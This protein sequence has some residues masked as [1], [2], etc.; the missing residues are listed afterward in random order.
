MNIMGLDYVEL[1][2]EVQTEF[3]VNI[4]DSDAT[5]ITTVG[6]FFDVIVELLGTEPSDE[7]YSGAIWDRYVALI[8]QRT[9]MPRE[10]I[11]PSAR[12]VEDFG[13]D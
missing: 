13:L 4:A 12:F 9:D 2:M 11:V 1:V 7:R 8:Q 3:G 10:R 5:K 6:A